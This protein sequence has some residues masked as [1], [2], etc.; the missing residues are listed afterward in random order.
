MTFRYNRELHPDGIPQFG[1]VAEDVE[2]MNPD[3]VARDDQGKPY[4]VRYEG[5]NATISKAG[6][7]LGLVA[8][9][10]F[11]HRMNFPSSVT[12]E[13]GFSDLIYNLEVQYVDH[14]PF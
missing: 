1:L 14:S 2:K 13:D 7:S 8:Q 6:E 4:S 12:G 11:H 3:L 10:Y 9:R 5:V